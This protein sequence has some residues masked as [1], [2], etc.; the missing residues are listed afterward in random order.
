MPETGL[1]G[2]IV[3]AIQRL[4][5]SLDVHAEERHTLLDRLTGDGNLPGLWPAGVSMAGIIHGISKPEAA[6]G[7]A[8]VWDTGRREP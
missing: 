1:T 4:M 6:G 8:D 7:M 2:R 3:H 5:A